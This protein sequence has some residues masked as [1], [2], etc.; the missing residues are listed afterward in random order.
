MNNELMRD[1][2]FIRCSTMIAE[3]LIS[4]NLWKQKKTKRAGCKKG[5]PALFFFYCGY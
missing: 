2:N 3:L 1:V 4:I 5:H